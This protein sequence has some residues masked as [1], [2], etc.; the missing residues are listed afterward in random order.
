MISSTFL[1]FKSFL[2]WINLVVSVILFGPFAFTFGLVSY[3][4]C[5]L[6]SKA[7]CRYNLLFLKYVC[8]LTYDF[9]KLSLNTHKIVISKH[10]SAWE[11]IFLAAYINNPI[12]ILKRELL[13]IPIFGW[14]LY[15]L[16]NISIDRSDGVSSL[17]KIMSI[18]SK[19]IKNDKTLIIF[20]EG[21]RLP[22]GSKTSIKKGVLKILESLKLN[23]LLLHHD[24]GRYWR[25]N[26]FLIKPGV[27]KINTVS[28]NYNNNLDFL[29][30]RIEEHFY[31]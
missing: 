27:I 20:P 18:S 16:K 6:I 21:T 22:Y 15:L 23:S 9:S 11:T 12:F 2:F 5:L 30:K 10:Q 8:S 28:M 1:I 4:T 3:S 13:M 17:K 26:S 24:A 29:K 19:H 25:K 14:C 31:P 7:W